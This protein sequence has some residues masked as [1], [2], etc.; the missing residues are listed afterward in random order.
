MTLRDTIMLL[1]MY[2]FPT[3][4]W[5][6][7]SIAQGLERLSSKQ[8]VVSSNL[9]GGLRTRIFPK[10]FKTSPLYER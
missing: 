7:A 1:Y 6:V 3:S 10:Q 2:I 9:T 8:E 5:Y 4:A